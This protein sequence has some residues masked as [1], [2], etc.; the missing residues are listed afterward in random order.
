[1][2]QSIIHAFDFDGVICDSTVETAITGWKAAG[3][4]WIEMDG[5]MPL[6]LVEQFRQVRPIIETGYEAILAMRML[7]QGESCDDIY[8]HFQDKTRGLMELTHVSIEELKLLFGDTR[9]QWIANDLAGWIQMNPLFPGVKN[10]L[11]DLARSQVW[12]VITTK[13]ERFVKYILQ[14]HDIELDDGHIFG[15]DRS[16]G[17]S[18]VLKNLLDLHAGCRIRFIEDRLPA[19][20]HAKNQPGLQAVELVLA[21]WGYNTE[22]DRLLAKETG[23]KILELENFLA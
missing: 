10:R 7:F 11:Q 16:M 2:N 6:E 9:D 12:Y 23:L 21:N 13:Q 18:A 19:L 3:R 22:A 5:P 1:M 4:L 8:S 17:K 14:A 20:M 15:L